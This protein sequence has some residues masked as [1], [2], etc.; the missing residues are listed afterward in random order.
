MAR[1]S[2]S[3][4]RQVDELWFNQQSVPGAA[5]KL[6]DS[7]EITA[8]V[9]AGKSGAVMSLETLEPEPVYVVEMSDGSGDVSVEEHVLTAAV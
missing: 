9:H 3:D 8:G 1:L 2:S 5:F 7:V 6:N 4:R